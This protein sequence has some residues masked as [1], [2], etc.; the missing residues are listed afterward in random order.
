MAETQNIVKDYLKV[1]YITL[2]A[3]VCSLGPELVNEIK[4]L[5]EIVNTSISSVSSACSTTSSRLERPTSPH[6]V[7]MV[8]MP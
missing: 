3:A 7:F 5:N 6:E 1:K 8:C 4:P 2:E